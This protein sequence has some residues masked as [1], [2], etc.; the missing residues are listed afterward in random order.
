MSLKIK[1]VGVTENKT[2]RLINSRYS[3]RNKFKRS[4]DNKKYK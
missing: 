2:N 1:K 3:K 4:K